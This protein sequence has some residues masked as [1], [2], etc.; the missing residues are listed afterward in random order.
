ML[1][2]A[3]S[4]SV[5]RVRQLAELAYDLVRAA[6]EIVA[7]DQPIADAP[8]FALWQAAREIVGDWERR[9]QRLDRYREAAW[10]KTWCDDLSRLAHEILVAEMLLRVWGS[11]LAAQDRQRDSTSARPIIEH[12]ILNV[13]H[14]RS[15]T[16]ELV[17]HA[18]D[19]A[20]AID[21]FRRRCER[22]TDVLI[23]PVLARHGTAMFAH[24]PRR[25]WE[26]GE[27]QL[28]SEAV[29]G[30][31][32]LMQASF[33]A[34]FRDAS[35]EKT[36]TARWTDV[37]AAILDGCPD[38]I[39]DTPLNRWRDADRTVEPT[40]PATDDQRLDSGA[41]GWS[42]L[43]RCLRIADVRRKAEG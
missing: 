1:T 32:Q 12:V 8:L 5:F 33:R 4:E 20:A 29:A 28:T 30:A 15:K 35:V 40:D 18:G 34:A 23:G 41:E 9:L 42:L 7:A 27:E 6:D 16:M 26:F 3:T 38:T 13:Q 17:V 21:R 36:L 43:A 31:D 37:I 2:D 22:W 24:D 10:A 14:A 11:I 25:A 19:P 39:H